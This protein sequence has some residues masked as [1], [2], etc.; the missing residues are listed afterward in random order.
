MPLAP[1][2]FAE[3]LT[4]N[5]HPDKKTGFIY[6]YHSRSDRHSKAICLYMLDDLLAA[7]PALK[8]QARS[9]KVVYGINL[10]HQWLES[11]KDKII[12]LAIG[13]TD[14][15]PVESLAKEPI[16]QGPA[17]LKVIGRAAAG[18]PGS[19]RDVPRMG[20]RMPATAAKHGELLVRFH[21][22]PAFIISGCN[23]ASA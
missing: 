15:G 6:R 9:E 13:S 4:N 22:F 5:K 21:Q 17:L 8:E 2:R 10:R 18:R 20:G 23:Q 3:W 7:S 19:L 11:A 1:E 16:S 12:D 14:I